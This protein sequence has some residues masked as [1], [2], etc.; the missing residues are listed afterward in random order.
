MLKQAGYEVLLADRPVQALE[1][2]KNNPPVHIVISDIEMPEMRGPQLLRKV[3]RLSPQTACMLMTGHGVELVDLP[4]G[5]PSLG[6]R[7]Q[8]RF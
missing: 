4:D 7:S 2:V 5:Y 3:A 6:N 8:R 1:I